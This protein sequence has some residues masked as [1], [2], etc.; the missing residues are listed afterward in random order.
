[1]PFPDDR[2]AQGPPTW[3]AEAGALPLI[4]NPGRTG[5]PLVLIHGLAADS[6]GWAR[7]VERLPADAM[8]IS[9]DLPC[10]GKAP[11][12]Q[13]GDFGDLA[14][15]LRGAFDR[16][17][18]DQV[19]LVGHSLGGALALALADIRPRR[20]A[21]LT[22][23]APAGLGPE[24]NANALNGL[25]AAGRSA[26]L[27][28]WLRH[29]VA[30]PEMIS[31]SYVRAAMHARR[32]PVLR[33]AQ[34]AMADAVFPDSVQAFDLR[35]ALHRVEAPT[36]II[37]GKRDRVIPWKHALQAPGRVSLNLFAD[38]GHMP[39]LELPEEVATLIGSSP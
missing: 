12:R 19:H 25:I 17:D 32:N 5:P 29:L 2:T 10:H 23:L 9:I 33:Q 15:Q 39:H 31:D 1:M 13:V 36:R 34:L 37:W 8:T 22:L 4:R 26:S 18:E 28:P 21:S 16:I 6:T 38:C 27:A 11:L 30:D 20:I 7:L 24:V 14:R 35:A 3:Q